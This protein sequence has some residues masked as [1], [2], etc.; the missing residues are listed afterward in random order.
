MDGDSPIVEQR[1]APQR[2]IATWRIWMLAARPA[3]LPA[4]VAPVLAGTAAAV[5]VGGLDAPLREGAFIAALVAALLLQ[6]GTNFANDLFDFERGA[7]DEGRLGPTRATHA[8][9]VT[10]SQMRA[11]T[12]LTFA[13]AIGLGVYLIVL[14]GWPVLVAG[15]AAVLAGIAYTGGPWPY[16]YHGLGDLF[17]FI[18]FGIVAAMGSFFVQVEHLTWESFAV[19]LPVAFTVTAILVV[20]NL[21]DVDTDRRAGKRTLAVILGPQVARSQ[22]HAFIAAPFLLVVAFAAT[23]LLPWWSMLTWVALPLA[24]FLVYRV[25]GGV[26]GPA[27]NLVLKQSGQLHLIFG[28]LLALSFLL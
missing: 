2:P 16:G 3:T 8:G 28:V 26:A 11:A 13:A 25:A 7:D 22:F 6:I 24:I 9:W 5:G 12:A 19:A 15:V 4:S 27:L 1:L 14:A 23:D 17:V 18:F 21:R 20:N 10:P